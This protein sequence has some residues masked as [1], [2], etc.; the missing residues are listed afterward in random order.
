MS[1]VAGGDLAGDV[2]ESTCGR[3]DGKLTRYHAVRCR[4]AEGEEVV[5]RAIHEGVGFFG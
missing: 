1:E 2:P 4:D 3:Y 5:D